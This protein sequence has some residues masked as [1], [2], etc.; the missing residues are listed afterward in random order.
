MTQC[1][2]ARDAAREAFLEALALLDPRRLTEKVARRVLA[3]R[4]PR[5][6][7]RLLGAGKAAATMAAGVM[8]AWGDEV[9][10][11]LIVVKDGHG[12]PGMHVTEAAHPW[13][14][15]RSLAGDLL[16]TGPTGN[17]LCDLFAVV[18]GPR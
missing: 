15:H 2:V 16:Q 17:N 11:G 14:D 4:V 10:R 12:L 8:T 9:R 3:G 5:R 13:S 18:V 6:G 7:I 1:V